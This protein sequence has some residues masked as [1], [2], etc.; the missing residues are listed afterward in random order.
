MKLIPGGRKYKRKTNGSQLTE[1]ALHLSKP[2]SHTLM[3][4][5]RQSWALQICSL[6]QH[7]QHRSDI[8]GWFKILNEK[9]KINVATWQ[10]PGIN[11]ILWRHLWLNSLQE[12]HC[13]SK[14]PNVRCQ[15]WSCWKGHN[16]HSNSEGMKEGKKKKRL[17][18]VNCW[19]QIP[20]LSPSLASIQCSSTRLMT[21][22]MSPCKP[23]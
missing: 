11:E 23:A 19:G 6:P 3:S 2:H 1:Q 12:L 16:P 17:T 7:S 5:C 21:V 22:R 9:K 8:Y 13:R 14:V 15:P 18:S 4:S 20:T 10:R